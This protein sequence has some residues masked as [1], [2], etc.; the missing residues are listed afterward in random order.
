MQL[1]SLTSFPAGNISLLATA[2]EPDGSLVLSGVLLSFIVIYCASK[3]G[4]E[5]SNWVGLPPVL[6]ELVGGVVV[7]IS[8]LHLLVFPDGEMVQTRRSSPSSNLLSI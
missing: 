8:A 7:G 4:G 5:L 1:P 6:G 3:I 2:T